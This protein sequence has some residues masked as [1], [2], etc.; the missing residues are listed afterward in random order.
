MITVAPGHYGLPRPAMG[1]LGLGPQVG[2]RVGRRGRD[3]AQPGERVPA[4]PPPHGSERIPRTA[5][6]RGEL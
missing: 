2:G 1:G 6:H 3:L 4:Y 5:P